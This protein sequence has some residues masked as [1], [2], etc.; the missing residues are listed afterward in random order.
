MKELHRARGYADRKIAAAKA[1]F[2]AQLA[3]IVNGG[4]EMS[5]IE[6]IAV[7]AGGVSQILRTQA[8]GDIAYNMSTLF[9][10]LYVPAAPYAGN[11][12]VDLQFDGSFEP[13][14][15]LISELLKTT[16][17]RYAIFRVCKINGQWSVQSSTPSAYANAPML[18]SETYASKDISK[19][20]K[21]IT[22]LSISSVG[23][24]EVIPAGAIIEIWGV[25]DDA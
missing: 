2:D 1:V 11:V 22:K 21:H 6:T 3:E 17:Q 24:G 7:P 25:Q 15:T 10:R 4:K 16:G 5:L 18:L 13:S 8:P 12:F 23:G 20:Y 19:A 14:E 9:V